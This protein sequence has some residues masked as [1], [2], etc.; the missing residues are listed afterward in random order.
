MIRRLSLVGI[1]ALAVGA[2]SCGDSSSGGGGGGEGGAGGSGGSGPHS[3]WCERISLESVESAIGHDLESAAD[4]SVNCSWIL[5]NQ[6]F[7]GLGASVTETTP[8]SFA[9]AR[10]AFEDQGREV[11][12]IPDV[13]DSAFFV[14]GDGLDSTSLNVLDGEL[15][16]YV[17][18]YGELFELDAEELGQVVSLVF[19]ALD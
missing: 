1:F 8:A 2:A 3:N 18:S 17:G 12:E 16:V 19:A 6:E 15:H 5:A 9:A 7:G 10:E 11:T 13:G 4:D 14:Q